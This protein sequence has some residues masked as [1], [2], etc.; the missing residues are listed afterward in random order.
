MLPK[1]L[2]TI[3]A[4]RTRQKNFVNAIGFGPAAVGCAILL[5]ACSGT[6]K[7]SPPVAANDTGPLASEASLV[8]D[9]SN[10]AD[11]TATASSWKLILATA[12]G[13]LGDVEILQ[14]LA[15]IRTAS[16]YP[17]AR[18]EKRGRT[19]SVAAGTFPSPR[20]PAVQR[21]LARLRA[22]E[23]GGERPFAQAALV[24]VGGAASG[25]D[26]ELNLATLK[27]RLGSRAAYSLQ[28]AAY[29]RTDGRAETPQDLAEIRAAAEAAAKRLRDD[30]D[31]AFY[32]HGPRRSMV[33]V[34][35]FSEREYDPTKPGRESPMLRL[36]REKYPH[37][38]V[39]GAPIRVRTRAD[40]EGKVQPSFVVAVPE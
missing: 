25:D 1:Y 31:E 11:V 16:G 4:T 36:L 27:Q 2:Q 32:Y 24:H 5:C 8:F 34:G 23:V 30:G 7:K 29:E 38:L 28:V 18:L 12:P 39:N 15:T 9:V 22:L 17:N 33:T 21:E 10:P 19:L 13:D 37:N 40:P 26:S 20:D 6:P 3:T 14:W 35:V